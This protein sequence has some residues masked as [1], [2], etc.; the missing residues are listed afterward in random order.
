MSEWISVKDKTPD[1]IEGKD[2]SENVLTTD[3]KQLY[4]MAKCYVIDAG[5]WLW[6]NCYGEINGDPEV[7]DNYNDY[8]THW[9]PL[10]KPPKEAVNSNYVVCQFHKKL[11]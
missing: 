8:I 7:D 5:G 11:I 10:P 9:M 4:I 1:Y 2:Y 6:G 3:G